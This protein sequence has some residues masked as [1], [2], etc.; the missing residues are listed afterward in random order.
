M[1]T[2]DTTPKTFTVEVVFADGSVDQITDTRAWQVDPEGN[3]HVAGEEIP[4]A[5]YAAGA[6][7]SIV[8]TPETTTED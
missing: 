6:W 1:T 4:V 5:T 7:R 8:R 2:T 3:L